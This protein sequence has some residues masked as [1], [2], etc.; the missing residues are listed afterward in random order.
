M[1]RTLLSL[2]PL[3][4]VFHIYF[5]PA[6]LQN[7]RFVS[8]SASMTFAKDIWN[9][10]PFSLFGRKFLNAYLVY[11]SIM[12]RSPAARLALTAI[13]QITIAALLW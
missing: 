13:A 4:V 2:T 10:P 8:S 1:G 11:P 7:N 6:T 12:A 5:M 9:D 3:L